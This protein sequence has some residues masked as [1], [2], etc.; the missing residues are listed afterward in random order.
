MTHNDGLISFLTKRC[1]GCFDLC[2]DAAQLEW[3]SRFA[4]LSRQLRENIG[5]ATRDEIEAHA[6][7]LICNQDLKGCC[8]A[9]MAEYMMRWMHKS[10]IE[11]MHYAQSR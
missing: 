5:F 2:C 3:V 1:G 6:Q 10:E 4:G 11:K 9:S 7:N 8:L